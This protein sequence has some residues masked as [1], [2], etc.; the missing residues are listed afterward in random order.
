MY[1]TLGKVTLRNG[2]AVEAGIVIGPDAEWAT[3]VEALLAHKGHPWLWQNAQSLTRDTGIE[4]RFHLLHRNGRPFA[5]IMTAEYQ[6]VGLF[7][8]VWTEPDD[9]RKGA[10]KSLMALQ[11]ADFQARNGEALFLG[12]GYDSVA[13]HIYHNFGF[14]SI[15]AESGYMAY[16]ATDATTFADRYFS[17]PT[18]GE[19]PVIERLAWQDWVTAAPLLL[20][21]YRGMVRCAPWGIV[22]RQS[23][24]S[25]LLPAL[26]QEEK[27]RER[28]AAPQT[29]VLR[30]PS[31][32]AVVGLASW[33]HDPLWPDTCLVDLYC[34]PSYWAHAD[35]LWTALALPSSSR[36]IAYVDER[37]RYKIDFFMN[38]SF[39]P[40]T[41]L[42]AFVARDTAQRE[43]LDV[44]VLQQSDIQHDDSQRKIHV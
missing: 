42:P 1:Q 27:R 4:V 21:K 19:P 30:H 23:P 17:P 41:T 7:G 36:T 38:R 5:N 37:D 18:A 20:G 9:R 43:L 22:G 44:T 35:A 29:V 8:H 33:N 25:Y 13:Y 16:Y 11:M 15:E 40:V 2:E 14:R 39:Q 32:A 6:G 31:T 12:T 3:R 26:L 24:E 10:S 28:N 34:H